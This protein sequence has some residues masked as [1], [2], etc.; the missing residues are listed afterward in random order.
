MKR[1][2]IDRRNDLPPVRFV[3]ADFE[4]RDGTPVKI[5]ID[6]LGMHKEATRTHPAGPIAALAPG[7]HT[8]QVW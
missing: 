8:F 5:D 6:L 4:E 7:E 1:N 2:P 3:G